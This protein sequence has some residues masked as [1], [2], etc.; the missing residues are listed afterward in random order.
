MEDA[1]IVLEPKGT[2]L[3]VVREARR[4]GFAVIALV[5]DTSLIEN[6]S[7]P[8]DSAVS[9]IHL[10]QTVQS[11]NDIEEVLYLS[12]KITR[13]KFK[14]KGVFYGT[15]HCSVA[16]AALRV[17]YLLP[18]P[19]PEALELIINKYLLRRKLMDLGLSRLQSFP[20]AEVDNW[21]T[22]RIGCTA[23]FKPVHG[24]FSMY[25]ERCDN[26]TEVQAAKRK[27]QLQE[28]PLPRFI[29]N[30]LRS[31]EE[32]HLEEAFDGE[33]LSVEGIMFGGRFHLIGLTSR[34]LFSRNPLIETGSCFPYP[35]ALSRKI[36]Q[37]VNQA[38]IALELTDGPVH[39]EVIVNSEGDVEI[40]DLN[41]RFIGYDVLQS[42]NYALGIRIEKSLLDWAVGIEPRIEPTHQS[43]SCIQ[44]VLPP[45]Q[46][47]F[48][49]I[50]FPDYPEVKFYS[51]FVRP[52]TLVNNIDR[53]V[54][55]LGCYLT[56]LPNME[57]AFS[58][59]RE[60]RDEVVINGTLLGA[61]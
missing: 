20:G 6:L 41:P 12:E 1:V 49:S 33:L 42:V 24:S 40:I 22:W 34:I 31:S 44:Y 8:Y 54:D 9:E 4:R 14:V 61:Y 21:T 28:E 5:T 18:T 45:N 25:V 35:H 46:L 27:W 57:A 58:R 37:L 43:V 36:I 3:E 53:E 59:S 13:N 60:L 2:M 16:C 55:F 11:W 32:Y 19:K 39:V 26:L 50:K 52:G 51:T 56:V 29:A 38:L 10:V 48:E 15:D 17:R 47:L 23:Y 30:Y 7:A